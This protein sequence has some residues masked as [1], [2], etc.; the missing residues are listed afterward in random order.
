MEEMA[1][2]G[3]R[4]TR[5]DEAVALLEDPV[6]LVIELP[7]HL[8]LDDRATARVED[9]ARHTSA[10]RRRVVRC[11]DDDLRAGGDDGTGLHVD[12]ALHTTKPGSLPMNRA[13]GLRP[14]SVLRMAGAGYGA[15]PRNREHHETSND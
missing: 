15:K 7:S 1:D 5:R 13:G 2:R 14:C 10:E 9:R 8:L 4:S 3:R 11:I 12:A 6:E